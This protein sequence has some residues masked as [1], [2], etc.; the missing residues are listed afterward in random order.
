MSAAPNPRWSEG[1]SDV[2]LSP[3]E[4][5]AESRLELLDRVIGLEQQVKELQAASLLSPSETVAVE[6]NLASIR[7][8]LTWRAGRFVTLPVRAA[9][10]FKRRVLG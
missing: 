2:T 7:G 4:Q 8:S 1:R 6:R 9:R 5:L 3:A 10:H